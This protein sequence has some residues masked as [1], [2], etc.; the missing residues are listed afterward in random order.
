MENWTETRKGDPVVG[1]YVLLLLEG[2]VMLKG[3]LCSNG[4]S[5]FFADGEK[6]VGIREV[7]HWMYLPALPGEKSAKS[8]KLSRE[9]ISAMALQGLISNPDVKFKSTAENF[10]HYA[11]EIADA[12]IVELSKPQP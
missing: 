5:A 3:R 7:T 1:E 8:P 11:V 6:L 12:L 10:A 4:W 2:E 9:E